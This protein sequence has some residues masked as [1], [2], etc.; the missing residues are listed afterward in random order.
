MSIQE[1]ANASRRRAVNSSDA[2]PG[3]CVME[4]TRGICMGT[5]I[6]FVCETGDVFLGCGPICSDWQTR[7][8]PWTE[9]RRDGIHW[10]ADESP[11]ISPDRYGPTLVHCWAS[12]FDACP[13]MNQHWLKT[14]SAM[15][16]FAATAEWKLSLD[17]GMQQIKL[18]RSPEPFCQT[19]PLSLSLSLHLCIFPSP[20]PQSISWYCL[21]Q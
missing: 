15:A 20:H 16:L 10:S 17:S 3:D 4:T 18:A 19:L 2:F 14:S 1:G 7:S 8:E 9:A 5:N 11:W 13:A 12:V 21:W 6:I